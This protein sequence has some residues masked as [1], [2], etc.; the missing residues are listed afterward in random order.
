MFWQGCVQYTTTLLE[1][2]VQ[3]EKELREL[4]PK[5]KDLALE[6]QQLH[7]FFNNYYGYKAAVNAGQAMLMGD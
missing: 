4:A 2:P 3:R 7:V 6:T 5:V 1:L